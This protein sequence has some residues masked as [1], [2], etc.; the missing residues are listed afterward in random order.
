[1]H[2]VTDDFQDLHGLVTKY[3]G[4][5]LCES[6]AGN[7]SIDKLERSKDSFSVQKTQLDEVVAPLRATPNVTKESIIFSR[8]NCI[9]HATDRKGYRVVNNHDSGIT[10]VPNV[11]ASH[12]LVARCGLYDSKKAVR[13]VLL[14]H[15]AAPPQNQDPP[16]HF[17]H[18]HGLAGIAPHSGARIYQGFPRPRS[19]PQI[20]R[21]FK[22]GV[23]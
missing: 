23:V 18:H 11:G 4:S 14:A 12:I 2:H 13:K 9:T 15:S 20:A 22:R 5:P 16:P 21:V 10:T 17:N 7:V 8:Y 3:A 1:M 6:F 19:V